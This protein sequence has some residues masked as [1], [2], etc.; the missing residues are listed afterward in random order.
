[1]SYSVW[2]ILDTLKAWKDGVA[3]A[4]FTTTPA[5]P[6]ETSSTPEALNTV[7]TPYGWSVRGN[8][9]LELQEQ[10]RNHRTE[11]GRIRILDNAGTLRGISL[12][13]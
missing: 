6:K 9:A 12:E 2:R 4:W 8:E 11:E 5:T 13:C 7:A 1:M 3:P 10:G